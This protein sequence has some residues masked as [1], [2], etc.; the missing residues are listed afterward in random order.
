MA[1]RA[2]ALPNWSGISVSFWVTAPFSNNSMA[3]ATLA[4]K[5]M[6]SIPR[7]LHSQLALISASRSPIPHSD[8]I[9]HAASYSGPSPAI[10]QFWGLV[11]T[12]YLEAAS[13]GSVLTRPH[14]MVQEKQ[15]LLATSRVSV[16]V[17]PLIFSASSK[18]V[19]WWLRVGKAPCSLMTLTSTSV[20]Y[21]GRPSAVTGDSRSFSFIAHWPSM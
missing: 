21:M 1:M 8:P 12:E 18:T 14:A 16:S 7:S 13:P 3:A 2:S 4:P 10:F 20:P 5:L 11:V 6:E 9:A 17:S 15:A 19:S